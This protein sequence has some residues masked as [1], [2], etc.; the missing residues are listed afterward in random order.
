MP[1]FPILAAALSLTLA[2]A[3]AA[4][5]S[6]GAATV[7][8]A[9]V[10]ERGGIE[11]AGE[12]LFDDILL[13]PDIPVSIMSTGAANLSVIGDVSAV[14]ISVPSAV[15]M[16][17]AGGGESLTIVTALDGDQAGVVGLSSLVAPGE[18]LSV[19]VGGEIAVRPEDL[20][21]GEYRGL[22]V[23]VAQYN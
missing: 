6:D 18:M 17:L 11:A 5:V 21:P 15:D 16:T 20:V 10:Q 2:S 4:Q 12:V 23:V 3:A 22:L 13:S 7:G 19:D 8:T 1:R 14:S 9:E